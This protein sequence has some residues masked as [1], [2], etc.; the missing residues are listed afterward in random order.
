MQTPWCAV[1]GFLL[2]GFQIVC[3]VLTTAS[4]SFPEAHRILWVSST[5][6]QP[7]GEGHLKIKM[8]LSRIGVPPGGLKENRV[9]GSRELARCRLKILSEDLTLRVRSWTLTWWGT[10]RRKIKGYVSGRKWGI[11]VLEASEGMEKREGYGCEWVTSQ[12]DVRLWWGWAIWM[13]ALCLSYDF[14]VMKRLQFRIASMAPPSS[15]R[16]ILGTA[17]HV[18]VMTG[19]PLCCDTLHHLDHSLLCWLTHHTANSALLV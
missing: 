17:F 8:R 11:C 1:W 2:C 6:Q 14:E 10:E 7:E 9:R 15:Q 3:V 16:L 13:C 4:E 12:K 18:C 5:D 19:K